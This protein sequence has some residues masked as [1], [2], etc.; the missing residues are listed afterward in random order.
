ML[1]I[2]KIHLGDC[3]QILKKLPDESIDLII[4][5]PPYGTKT[6]PRDSYM[7]GE[8]SNILPL[9]LP[10]LYRVLK[11][12]G[13]IYMFTSW[14][15]MGD[16]FLRLQ[17]FFKMQNI[18]I[19]DKQKHSGCYSTQSWFFSWEGI[20]FGIKGKRKIINHNFDVLRS[21][22]KKP[23]KAMQKPVD[24]IQK[25]IKSSANEGDLILDPFMGSGSTAIACRR[26]GKNFIG[27][28]I[29]KEFVDLANERLAQTSLSNEKENKKDG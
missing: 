1:E 27:I 29:N 5:D 26:E 18:L 6:N 23:K 16:W 12:N 25:I 3:L 2:N 28:E 24:I 4:T 19:W 13:A 22:E 11:K 9:V 14:S 20:F 7:V 21:E 15:L 17:Q 8:F 10:E